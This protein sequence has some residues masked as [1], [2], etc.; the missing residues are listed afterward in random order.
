MSFAERPTGLRLDAHTVR[1]R[2][3]T[4]DDGAR[5]RA[6]RLEALHDEPDAFG[7][8]YA[9]AL[10]FDDEYW[11]TSAGDRCFFLAESGGDVLGMNSGGLNDSYPGTYWMYAMYVTPLARGTVVAAMLVDAVSNWA[12]E[13]GA[14]ELY[15]HVT[16]SLARAN[17]F[18]EKMGF[19]DT[20]ER[21][22]MGRDENLE[23]LMRR[24]ILAR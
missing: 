6:I 13:Q 2:R 8:T 4:R 19:E 17:A 18:Y 10:S 22:V 7:S 1:V 23:L 11:R 9:E 12:R 21:R 5:V 16:A 14:S 24:R 20:G 15:L 3:T